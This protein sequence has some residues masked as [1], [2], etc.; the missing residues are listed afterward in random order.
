MLKSIELAS[1]VDPLPLADA[2]MCYSIDYPISGILGINPDVG[3]SWYSLPLG[4]EINLLNIKQKPIL[5][6]VLCLVLKDSKLY[7]N[8]LAL[9][10]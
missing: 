4:Q 7:N 9:K 10:I 3:E 8:Y 2:F 5:S 6:Q 1:S